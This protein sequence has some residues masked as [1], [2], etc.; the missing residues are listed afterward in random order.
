MGSSHYLKQLYG[1]GY[2]MT[3]SKANNCN[4]EEIGNLIQ[5][6]GPDSKLLSEVGTELSFRLPFASSK[7]FSAIWLAEEAQYP[8][9]GA[10]LRGEVTP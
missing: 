8:D 1:V 10:E 9:L 4:S 3:I 2:S 7:K 6:H 5:K